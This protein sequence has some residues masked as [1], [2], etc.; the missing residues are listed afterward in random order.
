MIST[1]EC[2]KYESAGSAPRLAYDSRPN[3]GLNAIYVVPKEVDDT[4]EGQ[5]TCLYRKCGY[6][7]V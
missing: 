2:G 5:R 4:H 1:R 7:S 6:R 3:V